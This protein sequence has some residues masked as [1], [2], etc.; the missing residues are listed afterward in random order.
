MIDAVLTFFEGFP[1]EWT[2]LIIAAMPLVEVRLSIPVA[3]EIL[4]LAPTHAAML[5]WIGST[6]PGVLL[7]LLLEPLEK[8]CRKYV[9]YCDRVFDWVIDRVQK[10]YTENYQAKG[11]IGL[12]LFI[13]IPL[14]V[15]GVWTGAL[16]AWVF[17]IKKKTAIPAILIG[18]AIASLI[19]TL[20]TVGAFGAAR[21]IG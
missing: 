6:I 14:P 3:I 19:V 13:A 16:A 4:G 11:A 8:P 10:R 18:T 17:G 7:P 9:P 12:A 2:T 1:P 5:S 21:M 15:T 20:I